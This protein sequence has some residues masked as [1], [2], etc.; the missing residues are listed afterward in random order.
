MGVETIKWQTIAACGGKSCKPVC[1]G[2]VYSTSALVCNATEPQQLQCA[3]MKHYISV[4]VYLYC[5]TFSD[6]M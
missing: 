3:F 6:T 4:G 2:F 1:A 5:F